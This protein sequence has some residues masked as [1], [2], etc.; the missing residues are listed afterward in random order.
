MAHVSPQK[1]GHDVAQ[2]YLS[3]DIREDRR[4]FVGEC[5]GRAGVRPAE[6]I[7]TPLRVR[8]RK[9]SVGTSNGQCVH[10]YK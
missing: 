10:P 6:L 5:T 2:V 1:E 3:E 7:H 8:G 4:T 9:L